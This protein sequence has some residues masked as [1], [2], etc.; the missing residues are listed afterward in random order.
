MVFFICK[1]LISQENNEFSQLEEENISTQSITYSVKEDRLGNLWIGSEEGIL[2]HNSKYYKVYNTYNGLPIS[3]GNRTSE[4]FIDS[5]NNI[6]AGL[7]KGI[8][9]YNKDLDIFDLIST[10]DNI[11]PLLI[12]KIDEDINGDIWIASFNGL[13][14]YEVKKKIL[15]N[16]FVKEKV[17]SLFIDKS[18]IFFSTKNGFYILN[19]NQVGYNQ[20][21]IPNEI[22]EIS[23]ITKRENTI[24]IGTKNGYFFE[25]SFKKSTFQ[26][27]RIIKK[28]DS[29]VRDIIIN[30]E[31][32][33]IATDGNGI[34]KLNNFFEVLNN[35][36]QDSNNPNSISSNGI[37][38]LE[39][40]K[41]GIL[42]AAT[43]GGGVNFYNLNKLPFIK[44]QHQLNNK[45]S[46]ADNFTRSIAQDINGKLWFGTRKGISIWNQ[47]NNT[48]KHINKLNNNH[49]SE[50]IVLALES[51]NDFMW[52]G[53]YNYGLYRVNINTYEVF[54]FT[55]SKEP[56]TKIYAI[57]K[58]SKNNIWVGGIENSLLKILPSHEI[59]KF[60]IFYTKNII[61]TT[62]NK[63][64]ASGRNGIYKIDI[65]SDNF[66]IIEDIQ[67]NEK[68]LAFSSIHSVQETKD[69]KLIIGTN[70]TG[71][72]IYDQNKKTINKL[73]IKNGLPS[74]IIQGVVLDSK[75]FIWASTTKGLV[76]IKIN[77][78]D[79]LIVVYDKKDGLASTE[80]NYGGYHKLKDN[81]LAFGGVNG[82]TIFKPSK[83]KP[84]NLTPKLVFDD[85]KLFNKS[86]VPSEKP[87]EKHINE[88]KFI[89]LNSNQNSIEFKF[90]GIQHIGSSGMK[91]A[92]KL[93]GFDKNWSKPST[94]NFANYINLNSGDYTFKVKAINK[95]NNQ[96]KIKSLNIYISSPW[97]KTRT[98]YILYFVL[99]IVL[100]SVIIYF[101][102]IMINKKNAEDQIEYFN[103]VTHEIKTPLTILLSSLENLTGN[104]SNSS[105]ESNKKIK[106][107]I[108][109]I[110]S[111]FEQML[112]FNN[113]TSKDSIFQDVS[114]IEL[115]KYL[116]K[117]IN[118]F[119]PLTKERNIVINIKNE[120]NNETFYYYRDVFDKIILNLVSNAIKYSFDNSEIRINI[121][122]TPKGELKIEISDEGLGI[123]KDQQKFILKR[124]YRAR[125]AINSQSPGTGLGLIMT[126]KLIQKT[127]GEID[128]YSV[129][130]VGTTF[131]II[132]KNLK[133]K[134]K[135]DSIKNQFFFENKFYVEN[136]SEI[137]DF[138][139]AK[140]LIV[141]DN[142]ELRSLLAE[143]LSKFFQIFEAS[144][145][146][147][148]IQ[149]ASQNFPDII[150]TDLIMPEM[151][152]ME[153]SRKLKE[154][155]N[156]NHIP[157]F[158]LTVLQNS[159]QKLESIESGVTEY[160]EKPVDL[161]LLLAKI[162][163]IL[164]FQKKLREKYIHETD[165]D[166]AI[167]FRSKNDQDFLKNL[168][169][170]ILENIENNS[171][172]VIELSK[173]FGMS[174]TSLYMKLKNLV[175][176]SPQ[177]FIIHSKLKY[178]KRLII[179]GEM[180]IKEVAYSSGFSNP[181]YFSTSFKKFYGQT[182]S[183]FI[184]SLKEKHC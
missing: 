8:C 93:E 63:I 6:W 17:E 149:S 25:V 101:I 42:W 114:K 113:V 150:L 146:L 66:K 166:N 72:L 98:A 44:V 165:T 156:L 136:Q 19:Q 108:K 67:P 134:Y 65:D 120:W 115:D 43:Y 24:F 175:D 7:E 54:N 117:R 3:L 69:K 139:N 48:W 16:S 64:L 94:N 173:I 99:F 31:Y 83:I 55:N 18:T 81:L 41:E 147:E 131:I 77:N 30:G 176:L 46:L 34:Y 102:S 61:E 105:K 182:P 26:F 181:K 47:K 35:Y 23:S 135:E 152:G 179:E 51:D 184:D 78:K 36:V 92:W 143:T 137:D 37:Y 86:V 140:I 121:F 50:S 160:I 38:D 52:V 71:L 161:K 171:F 154:D 124:Y 80:Y 163:N 129:E 39:I 33:Y 133:A 118:D 110:N 57:R 75:D 58:D 28:F 123:P 85:F 49:T 122:R 116:K 1:Q 148:G 87:L 59:I 60:P 119:S 157:V 142:D 91:Y 158:M 97:W 106:S 178:S 14:K 100:I 70:G 4:I 82:V 109:R 155:I 151:D 159:I 145:G 170:K 89:S 13:W 167:L 169:D 74:D 111:L 32:F 168:E 95:N 79:T 11:N 10:K 5:K 20:I 84:Q 15:I 9:L 132:L 128:F 90:T 76:N 88:T 125:N 153:M 62:D 180:N 141:E 162:I 22:K 96:S 68:S 107:T 144:N 174:R 112:N 45:N 172:S 29:P 21:K 164:K 56:I 104:N 103:N 127:G 183:K 40:S 12:S 138:S 2:K 126:K 130:N 53:T 73:N 177:D 27:N